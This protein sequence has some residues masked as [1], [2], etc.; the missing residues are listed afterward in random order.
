MQV[1]SKKTIKL[2]RHLSDLVAY[3]RSSA[4]K[5][6]DI[7]EHGMLYEEWSKRGF[8]VKLHDLIFLC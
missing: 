7:A 3:T 8:K 6:L 2:S 5:G 1:D 4:F